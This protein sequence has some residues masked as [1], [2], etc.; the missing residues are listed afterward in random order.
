MATPQKN[1]KK[2]VLKQQKK[3]KNMFLRI[4]LTTT[5]DQ[6]EV[7]GL[8]R[9]MTVTLSWQLVATPLHSHDHCSDRLDEALLPHHHGELKQNQYNLE[10]ALSAES[11]NQQKPT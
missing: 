2:T 10:L 5:T 4:C 8:R 9:E 3:H 1:K 11:I 6:V 7:Q